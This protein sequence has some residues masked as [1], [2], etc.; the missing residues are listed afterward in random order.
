M[1]SRHE[2]PAN[3]KAFEATSDVSADTLDFGTSL[4]KVMATNDSASNDLHLKINQ[5]WM[6]L[7]PKETLTLPIR[8]TQVQVSGSSV[9]FRVWGFW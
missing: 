2:I 1:A 6:T 4:V 9:P 7:K 5:G 8:S 3:V